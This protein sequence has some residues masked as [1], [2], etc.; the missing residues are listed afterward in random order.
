MTIRLPILN[1]DYGEYDDRAVMVTSIQDLTPVSWANVDM[2]TYLNMIGGGRLRTSLPLDLVERAISEFHHQHLGYVAA[3]VFQ[4]SRTQEVKPP[5]KKR[6]TRK[7]VK[8]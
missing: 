3:V 4:S 5:R 7:T 6:T 1:P 8:K 2:G